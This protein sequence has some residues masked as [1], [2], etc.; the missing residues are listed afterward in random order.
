MLTTSCVA[1]AYVATVLRYRCD[2]RPGEL[3]VFGWL[4]DGPEMSGLRLPQQ[5]GTP[6]APVATAFVMALRGRRVDAAAALLVLPAEKCVEVGTNKIVHRPRPIY[7]APTVLRDDAP[8]D[9]PSMPSGH[10]AIAAACALTL[11]HGA[12]RGI[13]VGLG[14]IAAVTALTRV[15]Q[16]AHW[17]SDAVAGSVMGAGIALALQAVVER[18]LHP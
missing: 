1:T 12:P 17:P 18:A 15:H 11:G 16:G 2:P 10:A 8:V 4:N 6:W 3:R 5:L 7:G 14:G 13:A 9:G